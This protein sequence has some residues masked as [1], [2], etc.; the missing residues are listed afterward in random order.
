M[1][2]WKRVRGETIEIRQGSKNS[3]LVGPRY[4]GI[5]RYY[6]AGY[7]DFR[8]G[9]RE[10]LQVT[11]GVAE[12]RALAARTLFLGR[13][14]LALP[15]QAHQRD[16]IVLMDTGRGGVGGLERGLLAL[17][18]HSRQRKGVHVLLHHAPRPARITTPQHRH[19]LDVSLLSSAML[20]TQ[21]CCCQHGSG[22]LTGEPTGCNTG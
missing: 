22:L 7:R 2:G 15:T 16:S 12:I 14:V 21:R 13:E 19:R 3:T 4:V 11:E 1:I 17:Q 10:T 8:L 18:R 5:P 6:G 20:P 9:I